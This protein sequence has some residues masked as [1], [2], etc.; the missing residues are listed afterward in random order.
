MTKKRRQYSAEFK[1][2]VA[3]E[4]AKGR[5]TISELTS[6]MEVHPNQI[7]EWTAPSHARLRRNRVLNRTLLPEQQVRARS[8]QRWSSTGGSQNRLGCTQAFGKLA[9]HIDIG[10]A[11]AL[12]SLPNEVAPVRYVLN[13]L[14]AHLLRQ[15]AIPM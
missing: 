13:D 12:G 11:E 9:G 10:I 8:Y 6:E 3:L 7:S 15:E 1:F 2:K 4:V 5:K 14:S